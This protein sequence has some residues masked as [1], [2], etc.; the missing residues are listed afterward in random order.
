MPARHFVHD[1]NGELTEVSGNPFPHLGGIEKRW[2]IAKKKQDPAELIPQQP[3]HTQPKVIADEVYMTEEGYPRRE[4]TILHPPELEDLTGYDG[5]VMP[6]I[7]SHY[8]PEA[9]EQTQPGEKSYNSLPSEQS[10]WL[11]ELMDGLSGIMNESD[12]SSSINQQGT[13]AIAMR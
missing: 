3:R 10:P 7:F 5:P 2:E 12:S 13:S 6:I 4:T 8:S 1:S 9:P 11:R